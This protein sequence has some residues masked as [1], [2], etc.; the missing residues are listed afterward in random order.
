MYVCL[1]T[2]H[3]QH[4]IRVALLPITVFC[5]PRRAE[6]NQTCPLV[7]ECCCSLPCLQPLARAHAHPS[8]PVDLHPG[9]WLVHEQAYGQ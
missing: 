8:S 2:L 3:P 4:L 7:G 5:S 1:V 6:E 9:Y